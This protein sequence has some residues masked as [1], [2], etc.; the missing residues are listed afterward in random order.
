M[1]TQRESSLYPIVKSW[2]KQ[3]FRC[4]KIG[5]NTGLAYSRI[6]I[7][8]VRD[9]GGDL[10]GDVE[11]IAIEVKQAG[12]PFATAS[13]QTL[14]YKVYADRVYL[15]ESRKT[16]FSFEELGIAS[17]LGIGLVQIRGRKCSEILSSPPHKPLVR[18][19]LL[20]LD[21]LG[22]GR[23]QLCS[24]FFETG[25]TKREYSNLARED[26][27][28][29]IEKEKGLIFWNY[30]V[31]DRKDKFGIRVAPDSTNERRFVCPDCVSN[32]LTIQD[33]RIKSW[34]AEF[35]QRGG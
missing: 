13:G 22:L 31:A 16:P 21:Q 35:S 33:K 26:T 18:L 1:K 5:T 6:D 2:M 14:G 15:A 25:G 8:G 20:L 7:V 3:H 27:W 11:T 32:L 30:E 17:H 12:S 19:N 24:C 9:S 34:L 28:K 29:A 23:C 4:F 10:S